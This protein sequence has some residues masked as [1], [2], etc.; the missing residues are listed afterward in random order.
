MLVSFVNATNHLVALCSMIYLNMFRYLLQRFTHKYSLD[1]L[2]HGLMQ[3]KSGLLL[4]WWVLKPRDKYI[5]FKNSGILSYILKAISYFGVR[6]GR[7]T[8]NNLV[9]EFRFIDLNSW[10]KFY[11]P[12]FLHPFTLSSPYFFRIHC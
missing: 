7:T 11:I 4:F 8:E 6:E 2:A 3:S 5:P 12:L 1:S 9:K 10:H